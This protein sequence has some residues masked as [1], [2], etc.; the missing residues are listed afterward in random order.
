MSVTARRVHTRT[1]VV[2]G[3]VVSLFLAGVVS[4]YASGHPDGLEYVAGGLGFESSAADSA[5]A[6]SPL[7]D[8]GVSSISDARLSGGAAGVVGVI[9][10]GL[11]MAGLVWLLRRRRPAGETT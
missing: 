3:V 9:A 2:V 10:V 5:T 1:V 6:G 11:L 4:Y 8:Y 7:A